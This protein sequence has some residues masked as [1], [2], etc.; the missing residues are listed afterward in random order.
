MILPLANA[1][2]RLT[3]SQ[4]AM[5][6][7]RGSGCGSKIHLIGAARLREIDG[8]QVVGERRDHV[9][10][11]VDDERLSFMAVRDAG[12]QRGDRRGGS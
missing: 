11:V 7:A 4:H 6:T 1:A 3:T 9:H 5:P 10:R 8:D 2:P 12:A